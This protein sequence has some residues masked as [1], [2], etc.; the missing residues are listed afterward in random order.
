MDLTTI[1]RF[2]AHY[3]GDTPALSWTEDD[4]ELALMV[5]RVSKMVEQ[6]LGRTVQNTGSDITEIAHV[7]QWEEIYKV[8]AWPIA[9]IT[10]VKY[11]R[12]Q[13]DW[14]R[15]DALVDG[16]TYWSENA[17]GIVHLYTEIQYDPGY[18]QV[19]YQGGMAADTA[20]FVLAYPDI[21]LAVLTQLSYQWQRRTSPG[22]S[23]TIADASITFDLGLKLLPAVQELLASHM[24]EPAG[25]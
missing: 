7:G 11:A 4:T 17:R 1:A 18:V 13:L 19:V 15:I 2:K 12:D 20:A 21:E 16:T 10:S 5:T 24:Q 25:I 3:L 9:S 6:F 23:K 14:S 8:A 22:G